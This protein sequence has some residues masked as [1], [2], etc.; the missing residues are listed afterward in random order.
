MPEDP[1]EPEVNSEL[2][3]SESP[4]RKTPDSDFTFPLNSKEEDLTSPNSPANTKD[5]D[6]TS[7]TIRDQELLELPKEDTS[8]SETKLTKDPARERM[9]P[10]EFTKEEEP[11]I[12]E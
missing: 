1:E 6:Q 9:L 5:G 4:R 11:P 7:F 10:S 8:S 2:E 12:R 3:S